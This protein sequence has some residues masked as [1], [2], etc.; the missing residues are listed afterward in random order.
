MIPN[1]IPTGSLRGHTY[2]YLKNNV[3]EKEKCVCQIIDVTHTSKVYLIVSN[4][5]DIIDRFD[6]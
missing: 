4:Y 1:S 5:V 3:V 2:I 6:T